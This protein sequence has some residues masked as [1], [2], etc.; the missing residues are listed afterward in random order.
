[1]DQPANRTHTKLF[2]FT[3]QSF[4]QHGDVSIVR[5]NE[6]IQAACL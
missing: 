2:G 4:Q 5:T 3:I 1:L 6:R